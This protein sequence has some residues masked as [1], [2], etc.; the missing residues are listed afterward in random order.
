[1]S[2]DFTALILI[3]QLLE[4]NVDERGTPGTLPCHTLRPGAPV[5][6]SALAWEWPGA[7]GVE[8]GG[9]VGGVGRG[10]IHASVHPAQACPGHDQCIQELHPRGARGLPAATVQRSELLC[11]G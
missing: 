2:D 9:C 4:L 11:T 8:P 6:G 5:P 7:I 1:M 3:P 10:R